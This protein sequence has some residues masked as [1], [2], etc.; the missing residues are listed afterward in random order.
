MTLDDAVAALAAAGNILPREA[1]QWCLD[2]WDEASPG[3]VRM[4]DEYATGADRSD[5]AADALF[6]AL[7][8]IGEK[9]EAKALPALCLLLHDPDAAERV[10]DEAITETLRGILISL[11]DGDVPRLKALVEDEGTDDFIRDASLSTLA[12]VTG[13]GR[14]PAAEM[15]EY[16]GRL[17]ET[18]DPKTHE[19]MFCA[20]AVAVAQLG[21]DELVPRVEAML[22]R[23]RA[24]LPIMDLADFR[25][26]LAGTHADPTGMAE[27]ERDR[28][29]P[30]TDAI[31]VLGGWYGFSEEARRKAATAAESEDDEWPGYEEP[32]VNPYRHVGR[33]DPCPCGSGKKFKK[34]CLDRIGS[35]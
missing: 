4:L 23:Y 28:I 14:I 33:N 29:G 26:I 34:C 7:H 9:R 3:L 6:F 11:F 13:L 20:C 21:C 27:F 15:A 17:L 35:D 32:Y 25:K 31:G 30:F 19:V 8:L 1:M 2:H 5:R 22:R 18:F 16:L 10:L 24:P 12:Y